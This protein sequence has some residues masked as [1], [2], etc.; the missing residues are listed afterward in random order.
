MWT[1]DHVHVPPFWLSAG[2]G[3]QGHEQDIGRQE[4]SDVRI[5]FFPSHPSLLGLFPVQ[6]GCIPL[7]KAAGP[8]MWCPH[9]AFFPS[10]SHCSDNCSLLYPLSQ[11]VVNIPSSYQPEIPCD[12][13]LLFLNFIHTLVNNPFS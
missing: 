10:P 13:L 6:V 4:E 5:F 11:W 3:L 1:I 8:V 2:L 12:L 9:T 7:L